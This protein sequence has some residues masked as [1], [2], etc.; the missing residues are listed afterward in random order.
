[1]GDTPNL[2]IQ[3]PDE[4]G[5]P[6]RKA[7]VEDPIKSVDAQVH[8]ALTALAKR[9]KSGVVPVATVGGSVVETT[10]HFGTPFASVP[11]FVALP[12]TTSPQL[13]SISRGPITASSATFRVYR[14]S[15]SGS[16]SFDWVATDLGNS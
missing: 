13:L 11:R 3:Y 9:T 14:T 12:I 16:V 5:V 8:A 6:S 7:W 15:G 2:Q 4:A 10:V 1:M